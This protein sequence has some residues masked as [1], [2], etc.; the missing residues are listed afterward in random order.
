MVPDVGA[1]FGRVRLGDPRLGQRVQ[2]MAA[3]LAR[4]PGA[5]LPE[6]MGSTAAREG[7]YR[8]L[9]NPRVTLSRVLDSHVKATVERARQAGR[10]LV[11]SD[12]T[13]FKFSTERE[14]LGVLSGKHREG[15]LGH[16]HTGG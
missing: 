7:A 1:E 3:A 2:R 13:E 12:T 14:G 10:V 9:S 15:F 16:L 11:I 4:R 8:F 5:S 6:A